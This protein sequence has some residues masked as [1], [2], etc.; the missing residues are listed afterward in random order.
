MSKNYIIK[1]EFNIMK[2]ILLFIYLLGFVNMYAIDAY[3]STT[4]NDENDG[5]TWS[6]AKLTVESAKA[7]IGATNGTIHVAAGTYNFSEPVVFDK[8]FNIFGGYLVN[9]DNNTSTRPLKSNGKAW[10]FEHET[11]FNG[12]TYTGTGGNTDNKNSRI[13]HIGTGSY[14]IEIN[15][16]VFQNGQGKH[17]TTTNE[18]GGAITGASPSA[19]NIPNIQI[20]NCTFKNNSVTKKD[21]SAGGMGGAVYVKGKTLI[22]KCYF[23]GNYADSGSSGG[24][25]VYSQPNDADQVVTINECVFDSNTSN[26]GGAGIRTS[27]AYKTIIRNS[28]FANNSSTGNGAA[29]Y[30][31]GVTSGAPSIDEIENC[32][33]YNNSTGV[34]GGSGTTSGILRGGTMK[35]CTYVNNVGMIRIAHND[36]RVYNSALWGNKTTG[37]SLTSFQISSG[38][39][40][41]AI[42]NCASDVS[43]SGAYVSNFLLLNTSNSDESGPNFKTPTSFSGSGDLS[44][45]N[46][47]WRID[48]ASVLKSGGDL[49]NAGGATDIAGTSRPTSGSICAIGAYEYLDM[50][51]Y[52]FR[53]RKSG[54]WSDYD[55]WEASANQSSWIISEVVPN[56]NANS[57][58]ISSGNTITI[59]D[60]VTAS[61]LTVKPTGNLSL[62]SGKELTTTSFII[63][64]DASGTGTF[65]NEGIFT[66]TTTSVQQHLSVGRN[67]YISSPV[68]GATTASINSITGSSI[69]SYDE[70]HGT[71]GP[72][73]TESSTLTPGKGYI[74]YFPC[75]YRPDNYFH[76]TL[77]TGEK[78]ISLT[79]T[80]GQTKEGFNLV[81]NPYPAHL[82]WT[83]TT[84]TSAN[85]L[86]SIWYRTATYNEELSKFVYSFVTYNAPSGVSV[87]AEGTGGYIPPMQAFWVKANSGGGTLTFNANMCSHQGSNPLKTPASK[88]SEQQLLRLRVSNGINSDETVIYINPNAVNTY[89]RFDTPKMN[90]NSSDIAEIFT[91]I[92]NEE[93]SINGMNSI[94]PNVEIPLGF[95]TK[96]SNDFSIAA[97]EI[98]NFDSEVKII[99]MDKQE[100]KEFDLSNNTSYEFKSDATKTTERFSVIFRSS[101]VTTDLNSTELE[102]N[103]SVY[104][105]TD[106]S[107][108][109]S[110]NIELTNDASVAVFNCAGQ[111]LSEQKLVNNHTIVT[112]SDLAKA[113]YLVKVN[114]GNKS[115][116]KKIVVN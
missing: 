35:N 99:L 60:N 91:K 7:V 97:N 103:I 27:G 55:S 89:D 31:N 13:L 102:N 111:K 49:T 40:P 100:N 77:N 16:I 4:G 113:V 21:N 39:N 30:F 22:E 115:V 65:V 8:S 87:P 25:A 109:V 104:K 53:S 63:E 38:V 17:L 51:T 52:H 14:S 59:N 20:R 66:A 67:W 19:G 23:Y 96:V 94:N 58:T 15:G 54:N 32:V 70:P 81:G 69:V 101:G 5:L 68:T 18:L 112:I 50:S 48:F 6:T 106:K 36:T 108:V 75:K 9:Y 116:M 61:V 62:E 29:F 84:A 93:L 107:F 64:S 74:V 1:L 72:W 114:V 3:V 28:I 46:P 82:A 105:N 2:K 71:S 56:N 10:E 24:G 47:D 45:E 41:I 92:A 42:G 12:I 26:V 79:R 98:Q 78:Q 43:I 90:N 95:F 33:L 80:S 85:V 76:G 86:P 37:G 11:I 110:S 44:S 88:K 34:S 73:V 57:I 83:E